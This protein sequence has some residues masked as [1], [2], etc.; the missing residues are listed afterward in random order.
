MSLVLVKKPN[1]NP[2]AVIFQLKM[3]KTNSVILLFLIKNNKKN[4]KVST[5]CSLSI[6]GKD[7]YSNDD[8]IKTNHHN[9]TIS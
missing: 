6:I 4:T 9:I 5:I 2:R 1:I 3:E 7:V 8:A